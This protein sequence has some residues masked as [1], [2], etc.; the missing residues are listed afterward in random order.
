MGTQ[1]TWLEIENKA[2]VTYDRNTQV[3]RQQGTQPLVKEALSKV[4][5]QGNQPLGIDVLSKVVYEYTM[6]VGKGENPWE[7]A[8]N[9]QVES[10]YGCTSR[11]MIKA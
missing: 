10:D 4:V 11:H 2:I 7:H 8:K 3:S 6:K 5:Q 1:Q 9:G